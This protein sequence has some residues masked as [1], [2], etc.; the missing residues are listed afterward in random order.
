MFLRG[1]AVGILCILKE[2][3]GVDGKEFAVVTLQ[4]RIPAAN[5][6]FCEIPAGMVYYSCKVFKLTDY[7]WMKRSTSSQERLQMR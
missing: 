4:P 2:N 1:G 5:A 7:S 3:T 6:E